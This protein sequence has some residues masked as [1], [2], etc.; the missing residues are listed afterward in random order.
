MNVYD[1]D[2]TIYA[3]DST[4]NFYLYCLRIKPSLIRYLPM[5]AFYGILFILKI[6]PK[7][8]FKTHFFR[9]LKG[10]NNVDALVKDFWDHNTNKIYDFYMKQKDKN[11]L[12]ISASPEFLLKD[13]CDRLEVQLIGSLV[14]KNTGKFTGDNCYGKEKVNRYYKIYNEEI[15][16]FYSDSYSDTPLANIAKKAYICD[17]GKV[18]EWG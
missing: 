2:K 8:K 18:K 4:V 10:I 15:N 1:F 3:G 7:L 14:N 6:M 12:I 16:E 9:F 11:D 5:Q 13:I 17:K